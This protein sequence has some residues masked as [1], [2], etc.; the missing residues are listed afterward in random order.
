MKHSL[1]QEFIITSRYLA[2]E[3]SYNIITKKKYLKN[4][5]LVWLLTPKSPG[6]DLDQITY[7]IFD[8]RIR[9]S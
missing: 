7:R 8:R 5:F 4:G 1:R 9:N 2:E 6:V 3:Y